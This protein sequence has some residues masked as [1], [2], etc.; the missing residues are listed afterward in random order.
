MED[1]TMATA[2]DA[3]AA[4]GATAGSEDRVRGAGRRPDPLTLVI[5]LIFTALAAVGLTDR[6]QLS[7]A[8]LRWLGPTLL[9]ALGVMLVATAAG[10]RPRRSGPAGAAGSAPDAGREDAA[11]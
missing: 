7:V 2:E 3:A 6:V 9:V 11:S 4:E 1:E 8:D 5:G 10:G